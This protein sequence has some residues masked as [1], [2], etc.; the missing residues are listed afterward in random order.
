MAMSARA[1]E[2]PFGRAAAYASSKA[3]ARTF[4]QAVA[5]EYRDDGRGLQR[6][7][8]SVIDSPAKPHR[9]SPT[10]TIRGWSS[11]RDRASGPVPEF[12]GL[13][14]PERGRD[15]RLRARVARLASAAGTAGAY[16]ARVLS[17]TGRLC[18]STGALGMPRIEP[19]ARHSSA[20]RPR[21][22]SER[23]RRTRCTRSRDQAT[24]ESVMRFRVSTG[25]RSSFTGRP[26]RWTKPWADRKR[27]TLDGWTTLW[28]ST[29]SSGRSARRW[30]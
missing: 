22:S 21:A 27:S 19:P 6:G 20:F 4:A 11:G 30:R 29:S 7:L 3:V 1:A 26:S 10:P 13:G 17:L 9:P 28:C 12:R 24:G 15:T 14:P 8:P 18:S 2:R 23:R 5:V 25:R 16:A